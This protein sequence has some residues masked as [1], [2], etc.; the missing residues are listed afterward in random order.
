MKTSIALLNYNGKHF[1]EQ[2]LPSVI[3]YSTQSDTEICVID[4]ASTDN[5]V[6]FLQEN[7]SQVKIVVLDKNY[8]F[9]GGYNRGLQHIE[10]EYFVLLNT[11][12][13]VTENWL[14]AP[15]AFLDKNPDVAA[16]QPKILSYSDKTKFEHAGAAGGFIDYLGYPFC[17]GRVLNTLETDN[18][19]YDDT[20]DVF[21]AT[22]ACLFIRS[23]DFREAGGFDDNFFAHQEEIDLCWRLRRSGRRLACVPQSAVYHVGGGTLNKENPHKTY[24]NYRNNLLMLHKN[25]PAKTLRKILFIRFFLD[26]LSAAAM[27]LSGERGNACAVRKARKDFGKLRKQY[28]GA[29]KFSPEIS[30][31]LPKS[32]IFNYYV[33]GKKTYKVINR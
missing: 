12:V 11:D 26:Y 28:V 18:G 8:G 30:E 4:N 10:A 22:G 15:I 24:L 32:M 6:A 3:K 20:I 5:S 29:E 27:I 7:F 21:W 25:L 13:E 1:L 23:K 19:Q 16:C 31:I 17:R 33:F 14:N 2:F 9:A